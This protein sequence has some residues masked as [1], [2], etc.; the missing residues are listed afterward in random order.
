MRIPNDLNIL[1]DRAIATDALDMVH[2]AQAVAIR[3]KWH[4]FC[5]GVLA[6]GFKLRLSPTNAKGR[7]QLGEHTDFV[8]ELQEVDS[9]FV[10]YHW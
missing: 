7:T 3:A 2:V 1:T 5:N 8:C 9:F 6:E 4:E 10:E